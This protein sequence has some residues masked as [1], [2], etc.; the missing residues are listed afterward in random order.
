MSARTNQ[1]DQP[2]LMCN[3]CTRQ[4]VIDAESDNG[5]HQDESSDTDYC[6]SCAI[7]MIDSYRNEKI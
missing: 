1:H 3:L 5:W 6:P 4:L 7:V 2:V